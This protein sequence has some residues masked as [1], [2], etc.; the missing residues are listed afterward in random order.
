MDRHG[1]LLLKQITRR[2][3]RK[4]H[5]LND[6]HADRYNHPKNLQTHA[7]SRE[8]PDRK[9]T[10]KRKQHV[11]NSK[12]TPI[13]QHKL[14]KQAGNNRTYTATTKTERRNKK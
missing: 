3:K 7:E 11:R 4:K 9:Q 12:P 14:Q 8:R 13:L 10:Q 2:E 5:P 6:H 1:Q